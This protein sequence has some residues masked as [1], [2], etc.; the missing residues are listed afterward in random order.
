MTGLRGGILLRDA[1]NGPTTPDADD[2]LTRKGIPVLPDILANSGGVLVSYFEW[3]R[4]IEN[5]QW[6]LETINRRLRVKMNRAVDTVL[7]RQADLR[8][9]GLPSSTE[10]QAPQQPSVAGPVSIDLRT[11]AMV[12][13]IERV[14]H[15]ALVRGIW[16]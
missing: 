14:A 8:E 6:D 7:N 5:E 2:L 3:V 1:A 13:A 11:S 10:D 4:N 12:V 16:P 15:V 9:T